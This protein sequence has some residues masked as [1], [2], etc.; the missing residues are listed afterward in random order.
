M[1]ISAVPDT[2]NK[3][4]RC[5]DGNGKAELLWKRLHAHANQSTDRYYNFWN[6]FSAFVVRDKK[7][8]AEVESIL[9]SEMGRRNF[10]GS[11]SMRTRIRARIVTT[12]SG[13]FSRL[14][15]CGTRNTWP[16]L[17]A[18]SDLKWEGGTS[19]EA[20]PCARESEHGS[21]LQFLELFL[22]F[23]GAGQ[24]IPGRG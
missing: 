6:F 13:T 12:I 23:R 24:E 1:F 2:P 22:G 10:F 19:L 21:L 14:S 8:L 7:Y 20:S 4:S 15:W 17:K 5:P 11:V 9:R 18:S 3:C 16:R